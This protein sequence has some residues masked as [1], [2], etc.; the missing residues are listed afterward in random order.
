MTRQVHHCANIKS[1]FPQ[2]DILCLF[3]WQGKKKYSCTLPH[4]VL[5][6]W[7]GVFHMICQETEAEPGRKAF[8][9][10]LLN[11]ASHCRDPGNNASLYAQTEAVEQ[12]STACVERS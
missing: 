12:N 8:L 10:K 5:L 7:P 9:R 3:K 1:I 6:L 11:L 2:M 4:K